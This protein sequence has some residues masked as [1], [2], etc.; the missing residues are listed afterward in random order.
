MFSILRDGGFPDLEGVGDQGLI[1]GILV[2]AIAALGRGVNPP[3]CGEA[4]ACTKTYNGSN[5]CW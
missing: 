3:C 5:I 2:L 1:C 4:V